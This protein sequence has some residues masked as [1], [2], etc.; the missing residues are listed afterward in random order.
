[1]ATVRT[2]R[3]CSA[4]HSRAV[5]VGGVRPQQPVGVSTCR[6]GCVSGIRMNPAKPPPRVPAPARFR[7]VGDLLL[8]INRFTRARRF[9]PREGSPQHPRQ[10]TRTGCAAV[11]ANGGTIVFCVRIWSFFGGVTLNVVCTV[12]HISLVGPPFCVLRTA[13][14]VLKISRFIGLF[15]LLLLC[16]L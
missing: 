13:Y 10:E 16:R 9:C 7:V 14:C 5:R 3:A 15:R 1:L 6:T 2:G 11:L 4:W 12:L 8:G